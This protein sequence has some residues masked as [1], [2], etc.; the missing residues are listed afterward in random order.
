MHR[1]LCG[2]DKSR[3]SLANTASLS[4]LCCCQ[5]TPRR[6][7]GDVRSSS[8]HS[9]PVIYMSVCCQLNARSSHGLQSQSEQFG[10][11]QI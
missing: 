6:P 3:I 11:E 8:T 1:E 5:Y 2:G 4:F 10:K 7:V 9:Q